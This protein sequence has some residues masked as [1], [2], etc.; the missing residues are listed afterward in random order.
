M[1]KFRFKL[2]KVGK[3]SPGQR[4]AIDSDDDVLVTGVPGSGKTVVSIYRLKKTGKGILFTYGKL[5]GK[6]IEQK[7]NDSSKKVVTIHKWLFSK[8]CDHFKDERGKAK[9]LEENLN[10]T[11]L[12]QTISYLK[13]K[14]IHFDEVLVDEGQDLLPNCYKLFKEIS[15]H[16]SIGA[17][18]A[19][20]VTNKNKSSNEND[21]KATLPHLKEYEL[22]KIYRSA[23]EV[24]NFA[25][26]FVSFNA[27]ANSSN[28]LERLKAKNSGA[29][30]PLIY[31]VNQQ[32]KIYTIMREIINNNP[33]SN[34]GILCE[35]IFSVDN[36]AA[37]LQNSYEFSCYHS[38]LDKEEQKDLLKND[39]KNIIITTLK[40]A[41]GI[42]FDIVIIHGIQNARTNNAEEYFVG[43]T[44]AKSEVHMIAMQQLPSIIENFDKNTYRLIDRT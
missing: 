1:G 39:L 17:D 2:P 38:K 27:R 12:S 4:R 6:T 22:D 7:V 21:I 32:Q 29:D 9:N 34:I 14:N 24:Y 25:R 42:E 36:C 26:Q 8:T 23:Y 19:Q 28:I 33:N 16:I 31:I 15:S 35:D 41:K 10:D 40:S 11:N 13:S 44:R 20:Q 5:L 18:E 43:V 37:N 30:K 3:L